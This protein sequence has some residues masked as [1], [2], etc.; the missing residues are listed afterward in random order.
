M[1][2]NLHRMV[3]FS[4]VVDAGSFTAAASELGLSKSVVSHHI[5]ELESHFDVKLLNRTTRRV[6]PTEFGNLFYQR[7]KEIDHLANTARDEALSFARQ[8]LGKLTLRVP[9]A[10]LGLR[11]SKMLSEF[12]GLNPTIDIRLVATDWE[13]PD[14]ADDWDVSF[15]AGHNGPGLPLWRLAETVVASTEFAD[16]HNGSLTPDASATLDYV[17]FEHDGAIVR[18]RFV[19]DEA[20]DQHELEFRP[21]VRASSLPAV[22]SL[23]LSGMGVGIVPRWMAERPG[24]SGL[25]REVLPGLTPM[26]KTVRLIHNFDDDPPR[27][28]ML[29]LDHV[30][31]FR[32]QDL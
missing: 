20:G 14:E 27:N 16:R 5:S 18:Q 8:P 12:K 2:R 10:V 29:L 24:V 32:D 15:V 19:C 25:T 6:S 3:I 28:V 4:R 30:Q 9:H 13:D 7:C 11:F 23:V 1:Y 31:E 22:C 21:T 26:P 17:G